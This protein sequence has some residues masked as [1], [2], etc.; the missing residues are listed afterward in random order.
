MP[1]KSERRAANPKGRKDP[2]PPSKQRLRSL[3]EEALV[4]AY[5]E[6]A[7]H[8]VLHDDRGTPPLPFETKVLGVAVTVERIDLTEVARSW[9]SVVAAINANRSRSSTSPAQAACACAKLHLV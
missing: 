8:G 7:T 6:S 1:G 9:P 4:D 3:V 5:D 2:W